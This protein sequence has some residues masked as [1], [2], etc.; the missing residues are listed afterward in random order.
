[1]PAHTSLLQGEGS[2]AYFYRGRKAFEGG[3][4]C[5][6]IK[7]AHHIFFFLGG[8]GGGSGVGGVLSVPIMSRP[9]EFKAP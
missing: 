5:S 7:G 6:H 8:G 3:K 9:L 2:H 4:P 1:M